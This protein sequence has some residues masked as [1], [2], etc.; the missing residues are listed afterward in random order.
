MPDCAMILAAGLG[1]RMRPLTETTPKPL[2]K[3]GGRAMLDRAIDRLTEAGVSKI[4]VNTHYRA[5][6]IKAHLQ[7]RPNVTLVETAAAFD[8]VMD[9]A[10]ADHP[11]VALSHE[12]TLLDSGGG[13][14][15]ALQLYPNVLGDRPFLAVNGDVVWLDGIQNALH[16]LTNQWLEDR[17]DVLLLLHPTVTAFGYSGLGDYHLTASGMAVRRRTHVAPFLFTGIRLL[18]PRFFGHFSEGL[19]GDKEPFSILPFFDHAEEHERLWG[20]RHDGAI[21]HV[22]TPKDLELANKSIDDPEFSRPFF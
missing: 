10:T 13:L 9:Q 14:Y 3:V 21:F 19:K 16:R 1:V 22:G 4:I 5:D 12:E 17:M 2:L 7:A 15:Q 8:D 11:V 20:V 18:H 6:Q